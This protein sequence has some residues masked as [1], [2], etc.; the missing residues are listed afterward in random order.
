MSVDHPQ[1]KVKHH[2][3][4]SDAFLGGKL[5]VRQPEKGFRAGVDSVLLGASVNDAPKRL[6]ELGAGVGV[7]SMTALT[8]CPQCKRVD[9]GNRPRNCGDRQS[10]F[11]G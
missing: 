1:G 9:G 4:T 10:K 7:A 8:Y 11:A 3:V 6:L 2:C 5:N